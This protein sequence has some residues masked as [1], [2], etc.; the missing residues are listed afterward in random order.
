MRGATIVSFV[1]HAIIFGMSWLAMPSLFSKVPEELPIIVEMVAIDEQ[2]RVLEETK[3]NTDQIDQIPNKK[4]K[5]NKT[6]NKN[7]SSTSESKMELPKNN[8]L[9]KDKP[10]A[11]PESKPKNNVETVSENKPQMKPQKKPK[12]HKK[13]RA[14]DPDRISL[15]ID[16]SKKS[17]E[18]NELLKKEQKT[19]NFLKKP[20]ILNQPIKNAKTGP[21]LTMSELSAIKFQIEKHWTVPAGAQDAEDLI[22]II[23][24]FLKPD[25]SLL[26]RPKIV[27]RGQL[28]NTFF[29]AAAESAVR[30]IYKAEPL[31]NL[32]KGKY[33]AWK[34]ITLRFNPRDLLGG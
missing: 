19:A 15:L 4:P 28:K 12:N 2:T 31:K 25:G 32:P 1:F 16:K 23:R 9:P 6:K 3:R 29:L 5:I 26:K 34:D 8:P 27:N 20:K 18:S 33:D 14:F 11:V 13:S 30:A 24:F 22:I 10:E 17:K 21:R 7:I